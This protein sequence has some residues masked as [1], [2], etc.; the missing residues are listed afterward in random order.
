MATHRKHV[1][2]LLIAFVL[3]ISSFTSVF[4]QSGGG[5]QVKIDELQTNTY[6]QLTLYLSVLNAQGFPITTLSPEDIVVKE[7]SREIQGVTLESYNNDEEPLAVAILID[8][9]GSMKPVGDQDPLGD[10][11]D[12]ASNFI[13][14]LNEDDQVAVITFADEVELLQDLT[15]NKSQ[16]PT[17]L[18][19]LKPEGA[20]AMND[21]LVQALNLL[22][23]RSERRAIVLITDGR[24]MG[25]QDYSFDHALNL[26]A[27]RSIPVYP[28]GFGDVD[29]N[30]LK[31]LA[32][33]SGG[34]EQIKPDSVALSDAFSSVLALFRQQYYLAFSSQ[35]EADGISHEVEVQVKYQGETQSA[36]VNFIARTPITI[37]V[38]DPVADS[39]LTG[40][41]NVNIDID[42]A[43]PLNKA[44]V[45]IDDVLVQTSPDSS[46]NFLWDTAQYV[47]GEHVLH[48]V[49]TDTLGFTTEKDL[50][51]IVELPRNE[52]SYWLIGLGVVVIAMITIPIMRRNKSA[53]AMQF[54]Q[55]AV[56][57]EEAGLDP[58]QEWD[59]NKNIIR[60][61]RKMAENDIRLK[62]I[63]A[64]RNH[65]VIER[66]QSGYCIR[67]LKPENPVMV[68]GTKTEQCILQPGDVLQMGESI[69]RFEYRD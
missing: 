37:E 30:Q 61:G 14:Q 35:T 32:E 53:K 47:A 44:D 67:S 54:V 59:L 12:A 16:I 33:L 24:P 42:S 40:E 22:S 15:S 27:S 21:A 7:D 45:F 20:T 51:Y 28:I 31:K 13:A 11:V 34:I 9:S 49:A 29:K 60:L 19:T 52:W 6:P 3:I 2:A 66:S 46:I 41:V 38:T 55:K 8:T 64:S 10:A 43:N 68:N 5:F 4:G 23:N 57:I 17:L 18:E 48:I 58:G 36:L 62:G 56:L 1:F 65:A 63:E 69:F 25:D 50:T 39:T 26:A